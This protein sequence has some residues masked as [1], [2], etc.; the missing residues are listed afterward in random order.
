MPPVRCCAPMA[1]RAGNAI[2]GPGLEA[3]RVDGQRLDGLLCYCRQGFEPELA[4]ELHARAAQAGH[5]GYARTERNCGYVVYVADDGRALSHA[6]PWRELI[7]ARQKTRTNRRTRT[8]RPARPHRPVLDALAQR[9]SARRYGQ[10]FVEHPASD[11]AKPLAAWRAVRQC[12]APV[13]A[14]HSLLSQRDDEA[15][16]ACSCARRR[17]PSIDMPK[18]TPPTARLGRWASRVCACTPMRHRALGTEAGRGRAEPT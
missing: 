6:L 9:K 8:A 2:D 4:A 13:A 17:R 16:R 10:L 18:P 7:F 15:C 1:N 14:Q 5:A 3:P 11:E 12:A